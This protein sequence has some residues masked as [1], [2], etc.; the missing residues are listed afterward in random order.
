MEVIKQ[1]N[2]IREKMQALR[3][4]G[5]R[6]GFVATM[7]ALHEGHL[8]LLRASAKE[9]DITVCSIFV[10][11]TQF[12]NPEDYKLYPRTSEQDIALLK[13]VNCDYL[14]EPDASE[15]YTQQT[16][17]QFSFG[18]LE[19]V[20]EGEHRPG[21][22]NGVA[23]IVSK[24]FHYITPHRAYFGQ[25]DLQQVA[26]VRQLVQALSFDLEL[27]CFPTVREQNGLAMSSRN[28][29][30]TEEQRQVATNLYKVLQLAAGKLRENSVQSIK[31]EVAAFL[32]DTGQIKL[33][34]FEVAHPDTLQPVQNVQEVKEVKE[35][36]LCIAAHV[37][38]VRLIDNML[39]N[40]NDA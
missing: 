16:L 30:L 32:Q 40:L 20:M 7:G 19:A 3:C 35:V 11:P 18:A 21:H 8:Q 2:I 10:N 25:K 28:K 13:T 1:V 37:G 23:T 34:Y 29:R 9:N 26:V 14:F 39:V 24:L 12:N 27:I 4:S 15:I 33:E 22:F 5:K 38:E 17:L 6:I 31:Q 36:A